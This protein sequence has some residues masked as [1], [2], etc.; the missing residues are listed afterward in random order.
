MSNALSLHGCEDPMIIFT[1]W[2]ALLLLEASIVMTFL[3]LF[4]HYSLF[5]FKFLEDFFPLPPV[6][7]CLGQNLSLKFF[8]DLSLANHNTES[9]GSE[10]DVSTT[11]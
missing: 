8:W 9:G 4:P 7:F 5:W 10:D 11:S 1:K 3:T 2:R 6:R